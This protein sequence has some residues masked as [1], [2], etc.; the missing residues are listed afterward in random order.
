MRKYKR[1]KEQVSNFAVGE[2]VPNTASIEASLEDFEVLPGIR[3]VPFSAFKELGP[4]RFYSV[5]EELRTANLA[6]EILASGVVNPL[7]V[8]EDSKGP[9]VL[10]GG[11]RFDAL[12]ILGA[13]SF[14]ALVVL[15]LESLGESR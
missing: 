7:I 15:D 2:D 10:E 12:R 11:H 8:V 14:P 3:E 5:A 13:K 1:A 4:V 6:K 9:Y